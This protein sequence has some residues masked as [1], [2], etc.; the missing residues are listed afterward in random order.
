MR[1]LIP[2]FG[3]RR[4]SSTTA[5]TSTSRCATSSRSR[6]RSRTRRCGSRA[7]NIDTIGSR[8]PL[9]HGR[10]RLPV[11]HA[12]RG[13]R[14]GERATTTSLTKRLDKLADYP[15][16]PNIAVVSGFMC[17]PTDEEAQRQGGG[18]DLL[19]LLPLALRPPRH[20][21]A[22]PRQHVGAVP[23][24]AAHARRRRRRSRPGSSARPRRS[25]GS[26]REFEATNV[27]Q[28]ILLNQTGRTTHEDICS[29]LE[30]FAARGDA[31]VPRARARA[32]ALEGRRPRRARIELEQLDTDG[33]Q[34]LRAPER[35][36]RPAHARGAEAEDGG[37]GS[38]APGMMGLRMRQICLV[39][40]SLAPVVEEIRS[41]LGLEVC[42]R[43]PGVRQV[44]A[45]ERAVPG[46]RRLSGGRRAGARRHHRGP[47]PRSPRRRRGLH[48]DH[49]VRRRRPGRPPGPV[50]DGGGS[51]RQRDR[52][53]G[54]PASCSCTRATSARPC[55]RSPGR[56]GAALPAV[57]GIRPRTT[58]PVPPRRPASSGP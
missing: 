30:L 48:G 38:G 57:P 20:G 53:S 44:R 27:D 55:S 49:P 17:A 4:R 7:R 16:N 22:R 58:G 34:G 31:R 14:V 40:R 6:C 50:R 21:R 35:G 43:D 26:S 2:M 3:E 15:T 36:H 24:V 54:V 47:V 10:A 12:G 8:G 9:G 42:H 23:G 41:V 46:R 25:G 33:P 51:H 52:L 37:Q 1:A 18:L 5:S 45:R 29:S 32:P 13:A 39:A 11:R 56:R 19:R 28:V